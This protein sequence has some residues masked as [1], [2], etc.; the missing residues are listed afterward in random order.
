M[1]V[2]LLAL[3]SLNR[4]GSA[5]GAGWY[6][7]TR[8]QM[9]SAEVANSDHSTLRN[10]VIEIAEANGEAIGS[11]EDMRFEHGY[12]GSVVFDIQGPSVSYST[13][14]AECKVIHALKANGQYFQLEAV[15]QRGVTPFTSTCQS[16]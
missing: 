4:I 11:L 6:A 12:S 5:G 14:Y 15:D 13:P 3:I 8:H 9:F 16:T 2:V 10:L 1:E 7:K